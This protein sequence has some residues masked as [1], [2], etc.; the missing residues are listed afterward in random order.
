MLEPYTPSQSK[1]FYDD[2]YRSQAG[3]GISVYQ[4]RT[5]RPFMSGH[6]LSSLFLGLLCSA[7][8][9]L[10]RETVRV[11]KCLLKTSDSMDS[12]FMSGKSV[13]QATTSRLKNTI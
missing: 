12:D 13:R 8:L 10:K 7:V 6:G 3:C 9:L 5:T 2:C 1:E 11:G 4:G